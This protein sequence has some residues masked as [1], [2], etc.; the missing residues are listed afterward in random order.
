MSGGEI[1]KGRWRGQEEEREWI[2]NLACKMR[3]D[4]LG[5]FLFNKKIK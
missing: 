1:P 4:S 2:L 5:F 3:N